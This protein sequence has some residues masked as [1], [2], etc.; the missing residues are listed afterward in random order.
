MDWQVDF[1]HMSSVKRIKYLLVLVDTFTGWVEAF[2][3]TNK[4][5]SMVTMI[6]VT[7]IIPWFGLQA[8]IQ[9]DNRPEFVSY[10]SKKLAQALNIHWRF[11]IPYHRHLQMEGEV[12]PPMD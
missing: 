7:D 5:A 12:P 3:M 8:S 10:I 4:K 9:S 11:H 2:P 1:I 6:L